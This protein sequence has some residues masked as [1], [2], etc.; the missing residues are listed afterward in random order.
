MP[1]IEIYTTRSCPYCNMAKSL[2]DKKQMAYEE[3]A[4]DADPEKLAEALERSGGR[5]TV[6]QIFIDGQHIGGYDELN[7]LDKKGRLD[8]MIG[9]SS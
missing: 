5:K 7:E 6:P 4:V 1:R 2:F 3:T 8:S 9:E